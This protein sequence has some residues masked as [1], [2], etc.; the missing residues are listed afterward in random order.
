MVDI[1]IKKLEDALASDFV[2]L[3]QGQT[4]EERTL[5]LM[6]QMEVRK[7]RFS[8]NTTQATKLGDDM[9][10]HYINLAN[11]GNNDD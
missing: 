5:W 10:N 7:S 11:K 4:V 8:F 1:D 6:K 3:P 9:L 2:P